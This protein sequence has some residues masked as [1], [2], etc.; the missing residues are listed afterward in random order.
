MSDQ[1]NT[2]PGMQGKQEKSSFIRE[3]VMDDS[4]W[5]SLGRKIVIDI[6]LAVV[7]GLVAAFCFS[8]VQRHLIS[9]SSNSPSGNISLPPE[10]TTARSGGNSGAISSLPEGSDLKNLE[11]MSL[12][13]SGLNAQIQHSLVVINTTLQEDAPFP[14]DQALNVSSFGVILAESALEILILS[15][16][17]STT[18]LSESSNLTITFSNLSTAPA[19]IKA[20]DQVLDLM[21]LAVSVSQLDKAT[22]DYIETL[23]LGNSHICGAGNAVLALGAPT[24]GIIQSFNY[25]I[26]SHVESDYAAAD[27]NICLLHT[28]MVGDTASRGLLVNL[29]GRLIGWIS[30]EY[31]DS[32]TITAI[33]ISDIRD[34]IENLINGKSCGYLGIEG[35]DLNG[36]Q[37]A[38]LM[39]EQPGIYILRCMENSPAVIAGLQRGDIIVSVGGQPITTMQELKILLLGLTTEQTVRVE[40]LRRGQDDYQSLKYDVSIERR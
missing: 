19:Y 3:T 14:G 29:E 22:M 2:M 20:S 16:L 36:D 39:L 6:L 27:N 10:E 33:G 37:A 26:I 21:V 4:P 32:G 11:Q 5:A 28:S 40:V 23:P 7:F 1:W 25:G 34:Y 31:M 30:P 15:P 12:A 38:T 24:D 18:Q 17:S 13:L 9:P 35:I 8:F